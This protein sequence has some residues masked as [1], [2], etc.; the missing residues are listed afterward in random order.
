MQKNEGTHSF[1]FLAPVKPFP[2]Y[3]NIVAAS[4]IVSLPAWFTAVTFL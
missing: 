1:V 4:L 2:F 3:S